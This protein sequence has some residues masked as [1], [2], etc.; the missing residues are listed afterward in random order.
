M[1]LFG[2]IVLYTFAVLAILLL[3]LG[4]LIVLLDVV[5]ALV[6]RWWEFKRWWR[7]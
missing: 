5:Q 7:A 3:F 2:Y 4:L 6:H 1:L